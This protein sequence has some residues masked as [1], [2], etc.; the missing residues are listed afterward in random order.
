MYTMPSNKFI[1]FSDWHKTIKHQFVIYGDFESIL[2]PD[3]QYKQRHEPIAAGLLLVQEGQDAKYES[4]FGA[5]C[6]IRFL[7]AVERIA[8]ETVFPWY[9]INSCKPMIPLSLLEQYSF[10]LKTRCYLCKQSSNRLVRDHDHFTGQYIDAA[11]NKCNLARR[12]KPSLAVV[13]HNLKGYDLHHILKYALGE[14]KSWGIS[15]ISQSTEK[16][17]TLTAYIKK[18]TV[19]FIDSYQFL[20]RSLADLGDILPFHPLSDQVFDTPLIKGKVLFPY[21]LVTSLDVLLTTTRLPVIWPGV[22]E[23]EYAVALNV[24][25]H[26]NCRCLLDYMMIYLKVDVFLLADI[27]QA[28][29]IQSL[30]EDCLEPLA[31]VGIPGMSLASALKQTQIPIELIQDPEMSSFFEGGIR[32]GMTFINRHHVF[33]NDD[34]EL[35]YIDINSLYGWALGEKLPCGEFEWILDD[36]ELTWLLFD[37]TDVTYDSDIGY[38]LEVD[39][40][41]PSELHEKL[42]DLPLA[43]VHECPPNS[44]VKK[45]LLT[46]KPKF[47]YVLHIKLLQ[48]FL[49][50]GAVA[51]KVHRAVRFKQ[52]NVFKSYIDT[53]T[54]KRSAATNEFHK[55]FFKLKS[56]SLFGKLI[57]NLKKR[58]NLRLCNSSRSLITYCSKASF[59]KSSKIVD[60]LIAVFLCKDVDCLVRPSYM[61]QAVLDFSKVRM[62]QLQYIDLQKYRNVFNC[63][64]NIVAGDTDSFFLECKNVSL[65]TQL[66]P[67]MLSDG[68]LDTSNYSSDDPLYSSNLKSVAGKFKDEGKGIE[69]SEWIF[70]MPKCYSLKGGPKNI[71]KAKGISIKQCNIVHESFKR[72]YLENTIER[73]PQVRIRSINHQLYTIESNKVALKCLDDKRYWLDENKSVAYGHYMIRS[74]GNTST[75]DFDD[76]VSHEDFD[77]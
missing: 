7:Q 5:D 70:L 34:T 75:D 41:I 40:F 16:F 23:E 74:L 71:M 52:D 61:C 27:F 38:I 8:T 12:V 29:R 19:K 50:L 17:L 28:F 68:L 77:D 9:K 35:L 15:C 54:D 36:A 18:K 45:L 26:F 60:D 20:N 32:G 72:I 56:N 69:Y 21:N 6:V 58:M 65:R 10:S 67:L 62:Y 44:R 4:F 25:N 53:N 33:A 22:T 76:L 51:T 66:L 39:L 24:W 13:F 14:F 37:C 47:N 73:L 31:F 64:I 63:T 3:P 43:P 1:Q 11:C 57:D 49:K 59:R 48:I 2:P 46:H 55:D 42:D 30:N